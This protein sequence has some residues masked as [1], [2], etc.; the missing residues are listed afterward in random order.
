MRPLQEQPNVLAEVPVRWRR[1][2]AQM[3]H[4]LRLPPKRSSVPAPPVAAA[5]GEGNG[6]NYPY[7]TFPNNPSWLFS[8]GVPLMRSPEG[9]LSSLWMSTVLFVWLHCTRLP[10]SGRGCSRRLKGMIHCTGFGHQHRID[11]T[12]EVSVSLPCPQR[13]SK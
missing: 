12:P 6:T 7:K 4:P 11:C 8:F 3:W 2:G 5:K 10:F 1:P 13:K 9:L